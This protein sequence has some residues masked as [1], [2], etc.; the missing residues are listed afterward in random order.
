MDSHRIKIAEMCVSLWHLV[1][2]VVA[3]LTLT[4]TRTRAH[5]SDYVLFDARAIAIAVAAKGVWIAIYVNLRQERISLSFII[6]NWIK[7]EYK[8]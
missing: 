5:K 1:T 8:I 7:P 2:L 4:A 3:A 6:P